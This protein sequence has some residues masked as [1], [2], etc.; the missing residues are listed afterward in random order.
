MANRKIHL[1]VIREL[2]I[3]DEL[4]E[5]YKDID[6]SVGL[7]DGKFMVSEKIK[8][9]TCKACRKIFLKRKNVA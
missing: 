1:L 7:R 9:V 4:K 2:Y 6:C 3:K 5:T 8:K